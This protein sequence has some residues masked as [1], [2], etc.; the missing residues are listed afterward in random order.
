MKNIKRQPPAL[1]GALIGADSLRYSIKR[2]KAH[3][4]G[5]N[6][7]WLQLLLTCFDLA[8]KTFAAYFPPDRL[9]L[10]YPFCHH[11]INS[12]SYDSI[13]VLLTDS[14]RNWQSVLML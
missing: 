5:F 6:F 4:A 12:L 9:K 10:N 11:I 8:A 3:F 7:C 2:W 13:L 1:F 14:A